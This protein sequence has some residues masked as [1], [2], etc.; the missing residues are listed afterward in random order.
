MWSLAE[1]CIYIVLV[2]V[3]LY[4]ICYNLFFKDLVINIKSDMG[5]QNL[6]FLKY[7]NIVK[8]TKDP[9]TS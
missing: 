1:K 6:R 4:R 8:I 7:L 3:S 9:P 2:A 5:V